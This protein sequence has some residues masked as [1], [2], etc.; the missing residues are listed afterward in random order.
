MEFLTHGLPVLNPSHDARRASANSTNLSNTPPVIRSGSS[1]MSPDVECS[2]TPAP[3]LTTQITYD[4][5]DDSELRASQS[6]LMGALENTKHCNYPGIYSTFPGP[7][8]PDHLRQTT[9]AHTD[10]LPFSSIDDDSIYPFYI[11]SFIHFP[12]TRYAYN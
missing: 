11:M 3:D 1:G 6:A 12:I 9:T 10:H 8:H 7:Y 2:P 5:S 4:F